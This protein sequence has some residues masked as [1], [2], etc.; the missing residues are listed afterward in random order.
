[1]P[2]RGRDRAGAGPPGAGGRARPDGG[3]E[4]GAAETPGR[5]HLAGRGA[6]PGRLDPSGGGLPRAARPTPPPGARELRA[7]GRRVRARDRRGGGERGGDEPSRA[8]HREHGLRAARGGS[9][10]PP[11]G[12]RP[13][14]GHRVGGRDPRGP[15]PGRRSDGAELRDQ[16]VP[17]RSGPLRGRGARHRAARRLALPG[18]HPLV[19]RGR[20]AAARGRGGPRPPRRRGA[21]GRRDGGGRPG[22]HRRPAALADRQLRRR[23]PPPDGAR[24]RFRLRP[25]RARRSRAMP[26]WWCSSA[27]SRPSAISRSC[28]PRGGTTTSSRTREAAGGSSGF[29]ADT[30]C[31][32]GGC[33][34]RTGSTARPARRPGSACSMS[35]R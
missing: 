18:G 12:H 3:H 17:G 10:V 21:A 1:M 31:S 25:R 2:G 24:R 6:R 20:A 35:R 8:R 13:R 11:R 14:R 9:R 15:R 26:A 34:T 32:A 5:P 27:R 19:G 28:D 23:G 4:P 33:A 29:A 22:P 16:Q 30:R 7:A